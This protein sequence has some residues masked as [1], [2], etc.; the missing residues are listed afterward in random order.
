M[1][2][3]SYSPIFAQVTDI[4]APGRSVTLDGLNGPSFWGSLGSVTV[5]LI[6]VS[7]IGLLCVLWAIFLRKSDRKPKRGT[8]L[9]GAVETSSGRRRRRR[10][11]KRRPSNPTRA[12]VGGLPPIGSGDSSKPPL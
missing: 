4:V 6:I 11:D 10:K 8:L 1:I 7:T 9:E 12:Q 5:T 2:F 3:P